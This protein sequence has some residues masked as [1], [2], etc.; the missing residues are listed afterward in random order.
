V[1]PGL[2]S[3][4]ADLEQAVRAGVDA[5]GRGLILSAS[6]SVMF[7]TDPAAEARALRDEIN[8]IRGH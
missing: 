7:S 3:Q 4:G 5:Q 1:A 8:R 2:G 6:R